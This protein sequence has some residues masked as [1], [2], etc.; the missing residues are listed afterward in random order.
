MKQ[1]SQR[2]VQGMPCHTLRLGQVPDRVLDPWSVVKNRL[3]KCSQFRHTVC[4][5][6]LAFLA[7]ISQIDK[8]CMRLRREE[9][10]SCKQCK[11]TS[12]TALY[13]CD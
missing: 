10:Y 8:G 7:R 6:C 9:L 2:A 1:C 3:G 5:Q 11:Q 12:A 13:S 4:W